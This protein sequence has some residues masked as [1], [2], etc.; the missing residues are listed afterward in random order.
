[1]EL[2][3]QHVM[4]TADFATLTL[5]KSAAAERSVGAKTQSRLTPLALIAAPHFAISLSRKPFR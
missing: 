3:Q 5:V 4:A 2:S 1:M